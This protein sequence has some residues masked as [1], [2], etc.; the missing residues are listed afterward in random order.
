MP[1]SLSKR[2]DPRYFSLIL[3]SVRQGIF[4]VNARAEITS[5]NRAAQRITGYREGEVLGRECSTVFKTDLCDTVCPLRKSIR[6]RERTRGRRAIV[7]AKDGRRIP[8][9]MSTYPLETRTGKLIGGV[10]VFEDLSSL[11]ALERKLDNKYRLDDIVSKNAEMER[12]F[13]LL[14][15]L[16]ESDSTVLI[17]GESGTGKELAA[18]AIHNHSP[19]GKRPFVPISCAAMPD[20][21]LESELFGYKKGAFTDAKRD[22]PGRIA[23]ADGG[24]LFLDEIADL[25][26]PLQVKLLRFLQERVYEPLGATGPVQANVRVISASNRDLS[27]M[28]RQGEFRE[29]LY[30]RLNVV[31]IRLPPLRE[32]SEDIPLLV[33]H[34]VRRFRTAKRRHIE[35]IEDDALALLV[36]YPFPGN[37]RELENIIERAFVVCQR[38]LIDVRSLPDYVQERRPGDRL[39]KGAGALLKNAEAKLI[40]RTLKKHRGN[41]TRAAEELGIHR[42]TLFRKLKK[43]GLN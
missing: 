29:D 24:T 20:T 10:E 16:A 37:I 17:S 31:E 34:F 25:A 12:I 42:V 2:L 3:D 19:R 13:A 30:F 14:P 15:L 40:V 33:E 35:G 4:T 36:R 21:L 39:G 38:N 18:K 6:G 5:F 32:R 26:K 27:E 43:Y 28:I 8:I 7:R 9:S 23:Q 41:R 1:T 11:L 22:K